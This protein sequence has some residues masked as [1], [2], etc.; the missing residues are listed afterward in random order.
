MSDLFAPQLPLEAA[1]AE[2]GGF[3][4]LGP[5]AVRGL[6]YIRASGRDEG[7]QEQ[8]ASKDAPNVLAAKALEDLKRLVIHFDDPSTPYDVKRRAGA[9]FTGTYRYDD[10][11]QLARVAEWLTRRRG[12][13]TAS[14]DLLHEAD[15]NQARASEPDASAWVSANAGTGKTDVLVKRML[16]L[17]LAGARPESI[18][19]LTYTKTAAAEMQNR[20]LKALSGWALMSDADLRET[21]SG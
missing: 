4:G 12:I 15:A 14:P 1:I 8:D 6:I 2:A 18:L 19:C 11:A 16:R 20:L 13:M 17:L 3:A 7:G 5:C 10:Y 21:L 9:A